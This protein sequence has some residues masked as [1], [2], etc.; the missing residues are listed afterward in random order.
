[1]LSES[2]ERML[3]VLKPEKEE[4]SR[5]I[6]EKWDLDFA[7]IGETIPEDLFIIEHNGEIKDQVRLK[8]LSGNSPEYD[9]S[10]KEPPKVKPLQVIKS[11]SPLEGLLSLISSPNYCCKKWV[12]QQYDSQVMA[13]TVIT[14]GTGSG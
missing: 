13:D 4:Q 3:M 5:A 12:Y 9:R 14:P 2:Q 6:F 11:F 10:W 8:A 1:M 7:I